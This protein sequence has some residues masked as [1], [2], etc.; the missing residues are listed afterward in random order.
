MLEEWGLG[1]G[2]STVERR[3]ALRL[4]KERAELLGEFATEDEPDAR[5]F[6]AECRKALSAT[7]F[8]A[9]RQVEA[10]DAAD[11]LDVYVAED[12]AGDEEEIEDEEYYA[13]AF[14]ES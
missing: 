7:A 13:D 5:V 4:A 9:P 10:H 2:R 11:D 14:E 6:I 3:I 1:L 8:E 12:G